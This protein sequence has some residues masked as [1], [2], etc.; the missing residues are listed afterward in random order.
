MDNIIKRLGEMEQDGLVEIRDGCLLITEKGRPFVRNVCMA[1]DLP[2]QKKSPDT[3]LF[4][5]TV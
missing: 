1:F 4:S 2:L 3:K 5:M